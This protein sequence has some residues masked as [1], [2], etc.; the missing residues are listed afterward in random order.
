MPIHDRYFPGSTVSEY[1]PP[2][3]R[4]WDEAVFQSGTALRDA[5][6]QLSQEIV[7]EIRSLVQT[8]VMPSGFIRSPSHFDPMT[9]FLFPP[10][11]D[12]DFLANSFR[13]KKR[14]VS[15][16]DMVVVVEYS[17]TDDPGW[18]VIT[19]DAPPVFGGA[20]PD[21][22]RT[23]F[24]FLEVFRAQVSM[25][26]RATA[27]TRVITNASITVGDDIIINGVLLSAVAGAPGVNEFQIGANEAATA[28]NIAAAINDVA[29][30]FDLICTAAVDVTTVEQV[31]LRA[32][33]AFAGAAGN[34]IT[35]SL[36]L[37]VAGCVTVNGGAG[38]TTFSGGVD[39]LNK[40]S[41]TTIYRH[42]NVLSST[43]VALP[44]DI[45][46]ATLN[47]ET[48][49]R[50][51]VQYRIRHT[52][53]TEAVNFK[54]EDGF[55][56]AAV[57]AQGT[58]VAPVAG[59]RFVPADAATI[60]GSSDAT[61]Y[62]NVDNGLWIAGD[63][64]S[65]A[66]TALGTADGYVYAV[67]IGF[68]FRR[69]NAGGAGVGFAPLTNANGALPSTHVGF[70]NPII[71]AIGAGLSDR[72]DGNFCD[73]IVTGD[74]LDLRRQVIPGGLDL[75]AELERQMNALLDGTLG[76]WAI[77]AADK[78]VLGSGSGDVSRQFLVCNEIGLAAGLG[79]VAPSSG[80]TTRGDNIA[81][82]DHVR[83]RFADQPVVE[84]IILPVGP[85]DAS[86]TEPGK[87][88]TKAT[89]GYLR[90]QE[91]DVITID[92]T[93]LD[94]T[95]LGDWAD[96]PSG[97]AGSVANLW[98]PGTLVTD[99]IRV[100]HDDGNWAG[101]IDQTTEIESIV[102]IGTTTIEIKLAANNRQATGGLNVA[103]YSLVVPDPNADTG[104][105]RRIFVE[106][107]ITYPPGSG[108]TD[109]PLQITPS[110]TI[111]PDG[112]ILENAIAQRPADW[113]DLLSPAFRSGY[114]EI[115]VEYVANSGV[116]NT[117]V[118]EN[119]VSTTPLFIHPA[120]RLYL[121]AGGVT[122][123]VTDQETALARTVDN[124][125]SEY[126]SSTRKLVLD[127]GTPLSGA[128]QTQVLLEYFPQD[129]CPPSGALG[130][131]VAV[132]YR[133]DAPQTVG[134]VAGAP[135]TVVLPDPF[136]VAPLV[137]SKDLWTTSVSVGS[138]ELPFPYLNP[139]DKIAVNADTPGG[140]FPAE[141]A[142]MAISELS[143]GDF[144]ADT[145]LLNLHQI[146]PVDGASE[147]AFQDLDLDAEFRL[148]YKFIDN[149]TYRP[150]AMAQPLSSVCTHK[151]FFPFLARST[152][153]NVYFRKGEV[154]LVVVSRFAILDAQNTVTFTDS[155]NRTCAAIYRTRGLLLLASE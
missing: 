77:D 131:Q 23:D 128:G 58:Q 14:T 30:G 111:Y 67:P 42:G 107:E 8:S 135:G 3:E 112:P 27:T 78:N 2:G 17:G 84:R 103:A 15:I 64:T 50:L 75:K 99:V 89:G 100:S 36:V 29:N 155:G 101:A 116:L 127:A 59:Y 47:V 5:E 87:Y 133:A 19:L 13:M 98:P 44:D 125:A 119:V 109:T 69:N 49:K 1:L 57:L 46:D 123:V 148:H 145:G 95:G 80:S 143:V 85:A 92:L 48:T 26:P 132:Y 83:R 86:G 6:F 115:A 81:N 134:V 129:P 34:A 117:K 63:G 149:L 54:T 102:G 40:P 25:S 139:S 106:L 120:R 147:F 61:L 72:P 105:P 90:W 73:V 150:T 146:V 91:N 122:P 136:T 65:T 28:A 66:A 79:G 144:A 93:L 62:Q 126:G 11:G 32:A 74:L 12:P 55:S 7:R 151:V 118:S 154:L 43:G 82:F 41:Q 24:V 94:A 113:Q 39:T 108:T 76:T 52:G 104:S 97:P 51:Q 70:A 138:N 35:L 96:A 21:V 121:T 37:A 18:N 22:K 4:S 31:N 68:V 88:V 114:R 152:V 137:M 33:D 60:A 110:A 53:Q 9:D 56:N 20:P 45:S 140:D 16:G 38:P 71:G 142:L 124:T 130:Y 141:W 153:D 10:I